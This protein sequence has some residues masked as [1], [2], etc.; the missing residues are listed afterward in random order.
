MYI[1][2]VPKKIVCFQAAEPHV[3]S[4]LSAGAWLPAAAPPRTAHAAPAAATSDGADAAPSDGTAA[5]RAYG[6]A[7]AAS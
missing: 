3:P 2:N 7:G 4:P 1:N 5:A 6:R